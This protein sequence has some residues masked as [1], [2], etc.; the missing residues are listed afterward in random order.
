VVDTSLVRTAME[1]DG[2]RVQLGLPA[3]LLQGLSAPA[4]A[5]AQPAAPQEV[6]P[7]AVS[8]PIAGNLHAWKVADGDA[9][10]EGDVIAVMEAMKMEMQ[11]SAHKSGRITL[12]AQPGT[13]QT[14]GAVIAHIR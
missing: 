11:V 1:I 12:A 14:L 10:Q 8:S 2:R 3:M 7:D 5:V 13:A 9:V 4:S 6:N